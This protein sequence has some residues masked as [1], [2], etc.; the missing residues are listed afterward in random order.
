M[1]IQTRW[2]S[3][4]LIALPTSPCDDRRMHI[5]FTIPQRIAAQDGEYER[6]DDV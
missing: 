2:A 5:P 6:G 3:R 4:F 1:D